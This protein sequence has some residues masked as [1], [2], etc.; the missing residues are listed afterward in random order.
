MDAICVRRVVDIEDEATPDLVKLFPP[1]LKADIMLAKLLSPIEPNNTSLALLDQVIHALDGLSCPETEETRRQQHLRI[2][3]AIAPQYGHKCSSKRSKDSESHRSPAQ[4]LAQNILC[5]AIAL[6]NLP[7]VRL[8]LAEGS[9]A[10]INE[11]T[12][13]FGRP[14][15]LAA[16][17]GHIDI[18]QYLLANGA[19]SQAVTDLGHRKTS[20]VSV[21][22]SPIA[23]SNSGDLYDS[24]SPAGS[25]LRAAMLGGHGDVVRLLL[26]PEHRIPVGRREYFAAMTAGAR[27]SRLELIKLLWD[28]Y[29]KDTGKYLSG[30][31]YAGKTML[32]E[33]ATYGHHGVLDF[34]LDN[35]IDVNAAASSRRGTPV[36]TGRTAIQRAAASNRI[37]TVRFLLDRGANL[38]WDD[39]YLN[40]MVTAAMC[41]HEEIVD[42]CL[43]HGGRPKRA[44]RAA[45]E[46]GQA[47]LVRRLLQRYPRLLN[48]NSV[49][50]AFY[51]AALHNELQVAKVLVEAGLDA[52][53]LM[54][55][56]LPVGPSSVTLPYSKY[57]VPLDGHVFRLRNGVYADRRTW[58][59]VGKY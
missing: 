21:G 41:G 25:A 46:Q 31:P 56:D 58:E 51:C 29:E 59:W 14:L 24:R 36:P 54:V 55:F 43:E 4:A 52:E 19:D 40:T 3:R 49:K 20:K 1:D 39:G 2:A 53:K 48:R 33:A 22:F 6:G 11:T 7:L 44:L 47:H 34:L 42:L 8:L 5:G 9:E 32:W 10:D 26:Q 37:D 38:Y 18:V 15:A 35:G 27:F 50:N 45:A 57:T 13:H 16:V 30:H 12:I 23:A 17:W 28:I